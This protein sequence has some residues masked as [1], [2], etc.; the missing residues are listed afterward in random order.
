MK[1]LNFI[2]RLYY[3]MRKKN[4]VSEKILRVESIVLFGAIIFIILIKRIMDF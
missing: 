3:I 4:R 1:D 2:G